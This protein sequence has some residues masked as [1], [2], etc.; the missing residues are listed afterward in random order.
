[1]RPSSLAFEVKGRG[2]ITKIQSLL[3]FTITHIRAKLHQLMA[4][5]FSVIVRKHTHRHGHR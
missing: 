4:S 1:M 5:S 3:G 2:D